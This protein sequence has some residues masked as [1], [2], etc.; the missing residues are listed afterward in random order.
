MT[1]IDLRKNIAEYARASFYHG[2]GLATAV[3]SAVGSIADAQDGKVDHPY[4]LVSFCASAAVALYFEGRGK[5]YLG[6]IDAALKKAR[7]HSG[8]FM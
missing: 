4:L 1:E 3:A 7:H 6:E 2:F 5:K 8:R